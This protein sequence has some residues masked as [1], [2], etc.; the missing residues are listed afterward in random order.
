MI[1]NELNIL[2]PSIICFFVLV[3]YFL[4]RI[5]SKSLSLRDKER[6]EKNLKEMFDKTNEQQEKTQNIFERMF[7]KATTDNKDMF[8]KMVDYNKSIRFTVAHELELHDIEQTLSEL[9]L[10]LQDKGLI[11]KEKPQDELEQ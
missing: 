9:I 11:E 1:L 2:Y 10:T 3:G 7:N 8:D 5:A 4:Y 6:T